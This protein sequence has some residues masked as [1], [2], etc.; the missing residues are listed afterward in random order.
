MLNIFSTWDKLNTHS[1]DGFYMRHLALSFF[2][3]LF[4]NT[5]WADMHQHQSL[6]PSPLVNALRI[7]TDTNGTILYLCRATLFNS[8][9]PGKTWAGYN[10]C[11]IPYGGKEYVV[12]QFT[13]PNQR[14]F[15]HFTWEENVRGA[16]RIGTDTNGNP[17]FLC[18]SNFHG[19]VQPGKTWPGYNHCNIAFAGREIIMDDYRILSNRREIIVH[20]QSSVHLHSNNGHSHY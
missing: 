3:S 11:N 18:Q 4:V 13:I 6:H 2:I 1:S 16:V 7:G 10:R 19:S 14:D 12:D 9:Q 17:L 20:S 5:L 15:G 8:V